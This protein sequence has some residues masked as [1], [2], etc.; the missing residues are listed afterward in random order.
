MLDVRQQVVD[1]LRRIEKEENVRILYAC[2]S[3]SRA[4]GFPSKDSDYDVRF[5]YARP[6]D[7]Y[8][9]I[10]E[11]RD[12]IERPISDMLDIN[13]WDLR[14]AL[15]LFRKSNPPLL[16]WLGSPIIYREDHRVAEQIRKFS[17]F[18]FSPRACMYHYLHMAK[19]NYR[20]YL[21]GE[22]VKIKKYF[23]V[24]R[25]VLAC[26]WIEKY[27]TMPPIEFDRLVDHFVPKGSELRSVIESLL[28]RK[29]A[30]EEMDYE[31]RINPINDF[32]D[33]RIKYYEQTA[34]GMK[35]ADGVQGQELDDLF[36]SVVRDIWEKGVENNA[37]VLE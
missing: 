36:R 20:E 30:G 28:V 22:Q 9:S 4:W 17:T 37:N 12:V 8:L 24:L 31:P 15:N 35:T 6:E 27:H 33:Q 23:Y 18:T 34:A 26:E 16:E 11:K 25:P 21:Q 14:K 5:I 7:W 2:E 29:R 1:E 19:G 10:F 32:L 3:G 13:G